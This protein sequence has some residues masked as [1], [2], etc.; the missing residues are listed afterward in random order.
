MPLGAILAVKA[1]LA[2][3][4]EIPIYDVPVIEEGAPVL[5]NAGPF[6]GH[7]G[8]CTRSRLLYGAIKVLVLSYGRE[9]EV[10]RNMVEAV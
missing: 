9:I 6:K 2:A 5:I 8:V 10:E 4:G 7:D 3:I 1:R